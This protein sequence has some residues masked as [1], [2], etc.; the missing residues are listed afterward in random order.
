MGRILVTIA[1][2]VAIVA[3]VA[4]SRD[5]APLAQAAPG[6]T[7]VEIVSESL[8]G[9]S[10][11]VGEKVTWTN[12]DDDIHTST[13]GQNGVLESFDGVGWN[14][15]LMNN[16]DSFS[17]TFNKVG[18]FPYTCQVHPFTMNATVNV[19]PPPPPTPTPLPTPTPKPTATP[20]PEFTVVPQ[21]DITPLAVEGGAVSVV[22]PTS[23]ADI[24]LPEYGVR[25]EIPAPVQQETLQVRLS[26][27]D[28]A[29]LPGQRNTEVLRAVQI[30]LFDGQG[31]PRDDAPFWFKAKL[32]LTLTAD[33]IEQIGGL[34]TVLGQFSEGRLA[35]RMLSSDRRGWADL[36][37]LFDINTRTFSVRTAQFSTIALTRSRLEPLRAGAPA[38]TPPPLA[39]PRTGGRSP[40]GPQLLALAGIGAAL[41]LGGGLLLSSLW[42]GTRSGG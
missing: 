40:S 26:V 1:V 18:S 38:L 5:P 42:R 21:A 9:L 12:L 36:H 23:P 15:V 29:S 8:P 30:D 27:L 10:V 37:T 35:L 6:T 33:E 2:V 24:T 34:G 20:F 22:Q 16:G 7:S 17:Y 19:K 13:S 25:L 39:A 3:A 31:N 28:P 4:Q 11:V 32:S 41:A 14:S